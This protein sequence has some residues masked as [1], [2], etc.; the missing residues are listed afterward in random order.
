MWCLLQF[1]ILYVLLV[2]LQLCYP[3]H[4][5]PHYQ[6][7]HHTRCAD[8]R[9]RRIWRNPLFRPSISAVRQISFLIERSPQGRPRIVVGT[10]SQYSTSGICD[11]GNLNPKLY[12][13]SLLQG[14]CRA[15]KQTGSGAAK[16]L[17]KGCHFWFTQ[18]RIFEIKSWAKALSSAIF[19]QLLKQSSSYVYH[20]VPSER[21]FWYEPQNKQQLF[22]QTPFASRFL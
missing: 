21:I 1:E 15:S 12:R 2:T 6:V 11:S 17:L 7:T 19:D 10:S 16:E 9:Y 8:C 3:S 13:S 14:S 20:I 5:P 4:Q 18:N 22:T